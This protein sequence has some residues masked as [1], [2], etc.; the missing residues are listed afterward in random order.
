M[1]TKD[2]FIGD[3]KIKDVQ[4][5]LVMFDDGSQEYYTEK[6]LEYIITKEPKDWSQFRELKIQKMA[7]AVLETFTEHDIEK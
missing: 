5:T 2:L 4:D 6:Q 3:K 1:A 7:I